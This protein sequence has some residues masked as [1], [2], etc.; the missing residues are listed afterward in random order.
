MK[1]LFCM[2]GFCD[3]EVVNYESVEQLKIDVEA[4]FYNTT[5]HRI[6]YSRSRVSLKVCLNCGR[7]LDG[8]S[9]FKESYRKRLIREKKR[10]ELAAKILKEKGITE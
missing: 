5:P 10:K 3:F 7:I 6:K 8:I 1:N 9:Y 2:I 4:E